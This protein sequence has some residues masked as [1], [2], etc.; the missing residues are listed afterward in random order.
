MKCFRL[1]NLLYVIYSYT[2]IALGFRFSNIALDQTCWR[3][4]IEQKFTNRTVCSFSRHFL[5]TMYHQSTNYT[6][7]KI[8]VVIKTD[9]C[10]TDTLEG[11]N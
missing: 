8:Q 4:L 6:Y 11:S 7:R 9:L 2:F 1:P 10:N 3:P 5:M